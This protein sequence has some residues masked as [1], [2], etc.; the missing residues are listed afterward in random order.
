MLK[1]MLLLPL[2]LAFFSLQ[3]QNSRELM[4][5]G[6]DKAKKGD[7]AGSLEL[8]TKSIQADT[9]NTE[10]WYFRGLVRLELREYP[11]A[12][13]DLNYVINEEKDNLKA[14]RYRSRARLMMA[15]Y[16]GALADL[17]TAID[18]SEQRFADGYFSRAL[19]YQRMGKI[20]KAC[21][22]YEK[23]A[24]LGLKDATKNRLEQ[25]KEKDTTKQKHAILFL[26]KTAP[27][28]SYGFTK[29]NPV[30]IGTG[31]ESGPKNQQDYLNLL[32]DAQG[33]PIQ[34]E[35]TGSCC[36]Y[37]SENGLMGSAMLDRYRIRYRDA[38]NQERISY[39]YIS[40]YDYEEPQVLYGFSFVGRK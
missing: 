24:E 25:C 17:D 9:G 3:A 28:T 29:E 31:Y 10:S 40:F 37:K 32:R 33:K 14:R 39:V 16:D 35:R 15:D 7:M 18:K 26:N 38:N 13:L 19:I 5:Q 6:L 2:L 21:A 20:D 12:I 36:P 22:D 1:K 8:L 11:E 4:E 30:K 34:F 23:A 27:D